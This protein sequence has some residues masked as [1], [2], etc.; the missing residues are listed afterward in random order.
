MDINKIF[1][2]FNKGED[3]SLLPEEELVEMKKFDMFKDTPIYKIGM[4]CK[5]ISNYDFIHQYINKLFDNTEGVDLD[6]VEEAGRLLYYTR[7][8]EWIK[9]SDLAEECWVEGWLFRNN[10]I[11]IKE[12]DRMI[13][14][15]SSYEEYEKCA[16]L[17]K[18]VT[19][20]KDNLASEK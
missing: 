5:I 15:F 11:I 8:F 9:E 12:V 3:D 1:R 7:A 10:R 17:L 6:D 20:L 19:F 16:F 13:F 14:Y 2:L 4:F 18:I